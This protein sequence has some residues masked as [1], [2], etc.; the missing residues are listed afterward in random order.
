MYIYVQLCSYTHTHARTHIHTLTHTHTRAITHTHAHARTHTYARNPSGKINRT[1]QMLAVDCQVRSWP[2][3]K[4]LKR[5]KRPRRLKGRYGAQIKRASSDRATESWGSAKW[6]RWA[7]WT[8]LTEVSQTTALRWKRQQSVRV[9]A[10][11]AKWIWSA[12]TLVREFTIQSV[13][14]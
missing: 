8:Q 2:S 9:R 4:Q 14:S 11:L 1:I 7:R 5:L 12:V 10:V 3:G 6:A 13:L